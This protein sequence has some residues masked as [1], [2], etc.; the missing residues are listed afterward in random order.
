MRIQVEDQG[1]G[2]PSQVLHHGSRGEELSSLR[3]TD[4]EQGLGYGLRIAALCPERMDG[5]P[6][7]GNREAGGAVISALL[8][9]AS[10]GPERGGRYGP[11]RFIHL[12]EAS[13]CACSI[14][15]RG[16]TILPCRGTR[17]CIP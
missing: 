2:F 14:P 17:R 11:R 7:A 16:P 8:P 13:L 10:P 15:M 1:T 5:V 12:V 3:G 9:E 4:G 6:E